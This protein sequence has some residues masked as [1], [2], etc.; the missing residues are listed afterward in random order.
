M[1]ITTTGM[2]AAVMR[3]FGGC[4]CAHCVCTQEAHEKLHGHRSL[5]ENEKWAHFPG[6]LGC[7]RMRENENIKEQR[8][9][10]KGTEGGRET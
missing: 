10:M 6:L 9:I 7:Q 5:G 4:K 1:T 3:L 8:K 2:I